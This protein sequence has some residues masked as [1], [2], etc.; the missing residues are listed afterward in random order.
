LQGADSRD[1]ALSL[2][3]AGLIDTRTS[4]GP[5][6]GPTRTGLKHPSVAGN[7]KGNSGQPNYAHWEGGMDTGVSLGGYASQRGISIF[8]V[9]PPDN[10]KLNEYKGAAQ[11]AR[12]VE[13]GAYAEAART[14]LLGS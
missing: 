13:L 10:Y 7:F 14:I 4:E 3:A 5:I 2:S 8:T 9:E 6:K 12:A 11:T 1:K